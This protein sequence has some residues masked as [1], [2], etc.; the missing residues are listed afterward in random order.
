M[1]SLS[2]RIPSSSL[3]RSSSLAGRSAVRP[4]RSR[5]RQ[6]RRQCVCVWMCLTGT[7]TVFLSW[8]FLSVL[9]PT[10]PSLSPPPTHSL[11][12][13]HALPTSF[14]P[15]IRPSV[16]L[17]PTRFDSIRF[18]SIYAI[19][20]SRSLATAATT[21]TPSPAEKA[22]QWKEFQIYRWVSCG[23]AVV[24]SLPSTDIVSYP[25]RRSY[26]YIPSSPSPP[27]QCRTPMRP[28]R[29][30]RCKRTRWT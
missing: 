19:K 5:R 27:P 9:R 23:P 3:L 18:N 6:C 30:Q 25:T 7:T 14:H 16:R 13:I 8:V 4:H 15:S 21:P 26:S 11:P 12:S 24:Q 28:R 2:S 20:I 10:Y 29:S 17:D 22:P 1:F